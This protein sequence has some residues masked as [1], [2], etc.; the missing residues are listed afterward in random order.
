[1]STRSRRPLRRTLSAGV[2][3]LL[4]AGGLALG[5]TV[6]TAAPSYAAGYDA[7]AVYAPTRM[8]DRITLTPTEDTSTS[9]YVTWRTSTGVA[10]PV[11][12][13][14]VASSLTYR[15]DNQVFAAEESSE[16]TTD[17]GYQQTFH[18]ARLTGLQPGTTYQYRVGD[19]TNFSEWQHFTTESATPDPFSFLYLGDVQTGIK[20]Q[21]SRV[22]RNAFRDRPDADLVLQIG[23]LVNDAMSDEQWGEVYEATDYVLG[24]KNVLLTPGNHEYDQGIISPQLE[25]QFTFPDNGPEDPRLDGTVH[26]TDYQGVR[27]VSLNSNVTG[28]EP[29]AIQTAWLEGVLKDNPNRWTVV[30]FHHPLFSLDEGRNN[31]ALRQSWLPLLEQYDVDLVLQ[32]HDHGYGR[33]NTEASEQGNPASWDAANAYSGPVYAVSVVGD[34][35]YKGGPRLWTENDAHLRRLGGG[36]QLYQTVDVEDGRLRYESRTADGRYY[37]GFTIVKNEHGKAVTD[38]RAPDEIDPGNPGPC[39]GCENPEYPEEPEEPEEPVGDLDYAFEKSL[40]SVDD[41]TA[42]LPAGVVF[43]QERDS[44]FLGDQNGRTIWE[45]DPATDE[46]LRSMTLPENIR[47][48]GID[49]ERELLY[50]GQQNKNWVVVSI[51]E[52]TFGQV[53][54]GPYPISESNRSID[55]DPVLGNVYVAIPARG[56]EVFDAATGAPRGTINGTTGAYYVAADEKS[57]HVA[58]AYFEE[59]TDVKNVEVFDAG[60]NFAKVW[61]SPTRAN[62]RQVDYDATNGLLYVG[63]TGVTADSGGFSVFDADSGELLVDKVGPEF[64]KDG[65]GIAVDEE[66]QRVYVSNRDHRLS[67]PGEETVPVAVT[68]SE[69]ILDGTE[70][71]EPEEPEEPQEPEEPETPT[72][73]AYTPTSMTA[74]PAAS[75]TSVDDKPVGSVV[76]QSSGHVYV[77]NEMRPARIRVIDPV[78]DTTLRTIAVPGAEAEGVRDVALDEVKDELYVA[79]SNKWVVL[80]QASGAVK[81]GPFDLDANVRGMD[82][83]LA[84]GR[85]LGATRGTGLT[86]MDATSGALVQKVE[87]AGENWSSHGVAYDAVNDRV[88]LSNENT[89]GTVGLRVLDSSYAVVGT[90]DV[91][92]PVVWRSVAVDPVAGRVYLGHAGVTD[93]GVTVLKTSDLSQVARLSELAYGSKVYGVSVDTVRGRVYVSARDRHPVGLIKLQR[94]A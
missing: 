81:R 21:S 82:V 58:V 62:A 24:T 78:A 56:V 51:A 52:A 71:E 90:V 83:D 86:V 36:I 44:L 17:L 76:E 92:A 20:S 30:Y 67:P 23:D 6:L 38:D 33:G 72:G 69:R 15:N 13:L 77:A 8:P 4:A 35:Q 84:R 43:S 1:M 55:V 18:R 91:A 66:R 5:T 63:F 45:L 68:I 70:P 87:L 64:G 19:R 85:V 65:Y 48:L 93:S 10:E 75:D 2:A 61:E 50:V 42:Q 88:Y 57:G 59:L 14:R 49:D 3:G 7:A 80:D 22:L 60:R 27:F 47:D 94:G 79:Y 26:Y 74:I 37:D 34:K 28:A 53:V 54:R 12:E 29:L 9:Q 31:R 41:V 89:A 25:R 39:L 40:V 73:K 32:G 11:V 16:M 46:V